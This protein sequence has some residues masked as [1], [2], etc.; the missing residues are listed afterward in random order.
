[1][2]REARM[3]RFKIIRL[4][5]VLLL[6]VFPSIGHAL[7]I[8]YAV[9]DLNDEENLWQYTYYISELTLES[10]DVFKIMFDTNN[11]SDV[12]VVGLSEGSLPLSG[13]DIGISEDGD[14]YISIT[15]W[16][17]TQDYFTITVNFIWEGTG[18][19]GSQSFQIYNPQIQYASVTGETS[20]VPE[21]G[22]LVLLGFGLL[23]LTGLRR[24][25]KR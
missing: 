7:S 20:A 16:P 13:L 19:P 23:G 9:T 21:P 10:E 24:K 14:T 18:I 5:V 2:N 1:M 17:S 12:E 4:I 15:D 3:M 11:Y 25:L 8:T 6:L 22:T